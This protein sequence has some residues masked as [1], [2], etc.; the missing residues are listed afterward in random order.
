[1]AAD[2]AEVGERLTDRATGA[3]LVLDDA[4]IGL[5]CVLET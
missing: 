4:T 3:T 2:G 5:G 1:V